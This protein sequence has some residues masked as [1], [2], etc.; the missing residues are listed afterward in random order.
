MAGRNEPAS[1]AVARE[2]RLKNLRLGAS[3][4][5]SEREIAV[6]DELLTK[7][8]RQADVRGLARAPELA[9]VARKVATM[10]ATVERQHERRAAKSLHGSPDVSSTV[11][12]A[13]S[14][15]ARGRDN[16]AGRD[17]RVEED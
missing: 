9:S 17:G 8:R 6:L 2:K 12:P 15:A 14:L 3:T 7:M 5:F 13:A 1:L 10:Q 16:R 11:E 4:S